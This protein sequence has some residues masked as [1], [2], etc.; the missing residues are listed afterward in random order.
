[1]LSK[2]VVEDLRDFVMLLRELLSVLLVLLVLLVLVLPP[3]L[4]LREF[5]PL[6][7]AAGEFETGGI[8]GWQV[9]VV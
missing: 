4:D 2:Y 1:M 8:A 9:S 6:E 3:A 5:F 7:E